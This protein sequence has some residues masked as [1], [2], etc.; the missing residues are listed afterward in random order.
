MI[1]I[2]KE[3]TL[4]QGT[5]R[6][7]IL[8]D[9][10]S[11]V[12]VL[13]WIV[14][15]ILGVSQYSATLLF[16]AFGFG[17]LNELSKVQVDRGAIRAASSLLGRTAIWTFT[18]IIAI[19]ILGWVAGL[20]SDALPRVFNSYLPNL[21][22]ATVFFG[23]ASMVVRQASP[24]PLRMNGK[25]LRATGPPLLLRPTTI[26]EMGETKLSAKA[27]SIG[28]PIGKSKKAVG[29]VVNGDVK[30]VFDTPMGTVSAVIA[31]PVTTFGIPFRGEK[32][33]EEETVKVSGKR[34]KDLIS[35]TRIETTMVGEAEIEVDL[36]PYVRLDSDEFQD[37]IDVGPV[38]LRRGPKGGVVKIGPISIDADEQSDKWFSRRYWGRHGRFSSWWSVKGTGD[39]SYISSSGNGVKA[40]WNGSSLEMK[41][42]SMKLK[43]GSD[44]FIYSPHALETYTP[45]HTLRVTQEKVTLNTKRF[46]LDILGD[47]VMLRTE[48]GS[49]RTDSVELSRDLRALLADT[50]KRQVSDVLEGQPIE[51]D[52][53]LGGTEVLLKK[54]A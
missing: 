12:F 39:W 18:T 43:V 6:L 46:T 51:L 34:I 9:V 29:C 45:L 37:S 52:E 49:K 42:D 19:L 38:S 10:V 21:A 2:G 3:G 36:P 22:I 27:D 41:Q 33:T 20:Q 24:D 11:G 15:G 25:R 8:L 5:R 44:G 17:L 1:E 40:K 35:Q 26:I 16:V 48:E 23:L 47:R 7:S 54:Y 30:A 14:R 50:A 4:R 28:L 32:A 13:A 53:M 31:G